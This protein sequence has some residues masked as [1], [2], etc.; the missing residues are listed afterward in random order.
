MAGVKG[1]SGRRSNADEGQ[2]LKV[3]RLAWDTIEK[4]LGPESE[5][6]VRERVDIA[7]SLVVKNIPTELA[8]ELGLRPVIMG[9]IKYDG[10]EAEFNIG[11]KPEEIE[12][13]GTSEDTQSSAETTFAD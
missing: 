10:R 1:K 4:Q 13:A 3:L 2:K 8:G 6:T 9:T 12:D 7:K 5:L 11:S